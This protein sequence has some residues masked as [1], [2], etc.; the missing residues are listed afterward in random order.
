[1]PLRQSWESI[2]VDGWGQRSGKT[3]SRAIPALVA[4][5]GPALVTSTKGDIVDATR[6][7]RAKRGQVWVFDPQEVVTVDAEP[8]F[9]WNPLGGIDSITEARRLADHFAAAERAPGATS[10]AFFDPMGTELC[11]NLLLAAAVSGRTV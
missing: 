9:W 8:G 3:P 5:P 11:A 10:D 4:Q 1:M 7:V 2:A 6:E